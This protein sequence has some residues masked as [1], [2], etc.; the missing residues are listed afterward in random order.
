MQPDN[1]NPFPVESNVIKMPLPAEETIPTIY[2]AGPMTGLPEFNFPAFNNTAEAFEEGGW[3]VINPAAHDLE[4][5]GDME[6]VA[7][8]ANY[9][10]CLAWDLDAICNECD[11]IA[12]LPGWENSKGARAEH[13]T[14]VAL[15]LQIIYLH[16]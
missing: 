12:M 11:A 14:A 13:A 3:R 8:N 5:W 10:D 9:R 16:E 2:I 4:V 1:D 6:G 15:G 7:K